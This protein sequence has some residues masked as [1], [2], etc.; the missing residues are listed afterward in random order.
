M[1]PIIDQHIE[2]FSKAM[3][4]AEKHRQALKRR[5]YTDQMIGLAVMARRPNG[6]YEKFIQATVVARQRLATKRAAQ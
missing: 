5:G 3:N 1:N 2:A 6:A 4:I